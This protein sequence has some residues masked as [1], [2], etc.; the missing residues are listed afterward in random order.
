MTGSK[1]ANVKQINSLPEKLVFQ[2]WID[3]TLLL[4]IL[5]MIVLSFLSFGFPP[6][7]YWQGSPFNPTK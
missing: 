3:R 4:A 7:Y 5:F 1:V 6:A 2:N